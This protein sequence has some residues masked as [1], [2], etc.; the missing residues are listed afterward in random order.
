MRRVAT[1]GSRSGATCAILS[2]AWA[3]SGSVSARRS[4]TAMAKRPQ[5]T[6]RVRGSRPW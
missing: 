1:Q 4:A 6:R 2:R 5:R 3:A